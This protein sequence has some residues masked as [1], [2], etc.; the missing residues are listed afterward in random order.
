MNTSVQTIMAE[1]RPR[2][3][4]PKGRSA[5]DGLY[6]DAAK[7]KSLRKRRSIMSGENETLDGPLQ[8]ELVADHEWASLLHAFDNE[9]SGPGKR[10]RG[11]RKRSVGTAAVYALAESG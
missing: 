4:K 9:A 7:V 11:R 5:Q 1:P 10:W 8:D 2:P 3:N 6:A